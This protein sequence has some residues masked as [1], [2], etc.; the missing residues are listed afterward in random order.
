ML[1]S[2]ALNTTANTAHTVIPL[3]SKPG[4]EHVM[5]FTVYIQMNHF[6]LTLAAVTPSPTVTH[7]PVV[8]EGFN[9]A[10]AVSIPFVLLLLLVI[11]VVVVVGYYLYCK[12][13]G[14]RQ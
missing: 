5:Y 3:N 4:A 2:L 11:G 1:A 10:A 14:M 9:I 8:M 6:D 13:R 7:T 12:N